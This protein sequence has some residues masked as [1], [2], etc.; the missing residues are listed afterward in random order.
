MK[1]FFHDKGTVIR[2]VLLVLALLNQILAISGVKP[3]PLSE[4]DVNQFINMAYEIATYGFTLAMVVVG[5]FKNNYVTEKGKQ[6]KE[7]LKQK[8]LTK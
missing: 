7:V 2:T 8:N 4:D 1:N 5:W 3:L 6:Q